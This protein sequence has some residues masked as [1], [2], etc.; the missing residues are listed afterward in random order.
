MS[1]PTDAELEAMEKRCEAA[2]KGP[3]E[4]FKNQV[5]P[6][7][8]VGVWGPDGD[9]IC[10]CWGNL[11]YSTEPTDDADFIAHARS[12]VP[13]LIAALREARKERDEAEARYVEQLERADAAVGDRDHRVAHVLTE[14]RLLI[15]YCLSDGGQLPDLDL[16]L[17]AA[18]V[19]RVKRLEKVAEAARALRD[20]CYKD[21]SDG[22]TMR[23]LR[24]QLFELLDTH[25]KAAALSAM[26]IDKT[27]IKPEESE[28]NSEIKDYK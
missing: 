23:D 6:D 5:H 17:T 26:E 9:E 8:T 10:A 14:N 16:S 4:W 11:A 25:D 3:W 12:D 13:A 21:Y 27:L 2:T 18:E 1:D 28:F 19:E 7:G 22:P 15:E 24:D 20:E